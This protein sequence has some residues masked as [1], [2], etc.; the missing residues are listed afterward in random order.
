MLVLVYQDDNDNNN[1]Q[2]SSMV[3]ANID[4]VIDL[5]CE[6]LRSEESK[7]YK[8]RNSKDTSHQFFFVLI[9]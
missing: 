3:R 6:F 5:L 8:M 1:V 7:Y 2:D 9:L 4:G